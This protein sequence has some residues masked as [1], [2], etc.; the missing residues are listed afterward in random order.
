MVVEITVI[1]SMDEESEEALEAC[2]KAARELLRSYGIKAYVIPLN[3]WISTPFEVLGSEDLPLVM[4]NG[5][6]LASGRAPTAREIINYVLTKYRL[7]NRNVLPALPRKIA[8]PN[9]MGT[10]ATYA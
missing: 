9:P 6:V 10:A 8:E 1:M 4:I 2:Y 7:P 3:T 5:D